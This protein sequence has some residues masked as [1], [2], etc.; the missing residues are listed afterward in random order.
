MKIKA[1]IFD[2]G[3]VI[4]ELDFSRFFKDV[5]LISP[6]NK[7][8]SMLL[9][10][11]WRQSDIF[12]QG[13]MTNDEFYHQSCELLQYRDVS[14]DRFYESFNSVIDHYNEEIIDFIKKIKDLK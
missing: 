13:K 4:V 3:G 1:I 11:F 14:Q 6:I 10:E 7:P 8:H 5:I 9:L 12:H 2:L